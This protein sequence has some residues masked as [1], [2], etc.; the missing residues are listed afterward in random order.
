MDPPLGLLRRLRPPP[1]AQHLIARRN[2]HLV[3]VR[4]RDRVRLGLG[5]GF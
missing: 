1:L 5:L 2:P 3:R 4:V